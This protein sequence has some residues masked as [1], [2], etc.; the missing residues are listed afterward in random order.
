M[1]LTLKNKYTNEI[2]YCD[3]MTKFIN[4]VDGIFIEVYQNN[5]FGKNE[6]K[7][8]K[9]SAFEIITKNSRPLP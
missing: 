7:Y 2:F 5:N 1:K 9:K 3:D 8:M 6:K 4:G